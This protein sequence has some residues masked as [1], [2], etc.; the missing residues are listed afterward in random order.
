MNLETLKNNLPLNAKDV[1]INLMTILK[2]EGT[3]DLNSKQRFNVLLSCAYAVKNKDLIT[4]ILNDANLHLSKNQIE[5]AQSAAIIMSMNNIYYRFIHLVNDKSF[6]NMP[7]GL[8]MTILNNPGIDKPDFELN[9]LAVSA[10]N[11]CGM[12]IEAHSNELIKS[13]FSKVAIQ[14]TIR[15]AAVI[16]SVAVAMVIN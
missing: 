13:G 12:C 14:S 11:G 3:P 15:I 8:R 6:A 9:C 4:A 1:R 10:I 7:A 2:E 16:N 5:A